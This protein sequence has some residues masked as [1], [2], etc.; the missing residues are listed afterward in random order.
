MPLLG[1]LLSYL[2]YKLIK[3]HIYEH[4]EAAKRVV[5]FIPYQ[6]TF[7]FTL[8]WYVALMKNYFKSS[9]FRH[10]HHDVHYFAILISLM[11]LFPI[12][13]L[14]LTRF[15][16]LRRARNVEWVTQGK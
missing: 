13:A 16:L 4:A 2:L 7:S 1:L 8:M 10:S 3:K 5:K 6:V 9:D 12:V 15:Y 11:V 14:P